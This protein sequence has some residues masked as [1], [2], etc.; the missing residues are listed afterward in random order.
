MTPL[1][2]W[3]RETA[4]LPELTESALR[5]YHLGKLRDIVGYAKAR[6]RYYRERFVEHGEIK[7]LAD[8]QALPFTDAAD[9]SRNPLDFLC[10]PPDD[11]SRIVTLRTSG[12]TGSGKRIFS[13][14]ED[15]E[16]T[17]EFFRY[18]M[19]TF[20]VRGD[21]ALLFMPGESPGGV[22]NLL[23]RGL[24][25]LG[26]A[27]R[28]YGPVSD[29]GGA[30]LALL[31]YGPDVAVGLPSQMLRLARETA[32]VFKLKSV[33]LASDYISPALE[34][35]IEAAWGC[36][37]FTHYGL[38]ESGLGGAVS[39]EAHDG[40]HM[41]DNDLYF[42][43]IDPASG[44]PLPDG[45]CGEIVF[46]TL[47]HAAMPLIRYRTGD[48]SRIIP[49]RCPC[50]SAVRRLGRIAGR[51][52]EPIR[53]RSGQSLSTTDLDDI[54]YKYP[55]IAAFAADLSSDGGTETLTITVKLAGASPSP[56]TIPE[57]DALPV[58]VAIKLGTPGFFTTG[59]LK[60]KITGVSS[61]V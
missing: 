57:L 5:G 10:V 52:A 29:Y 56:P 16:L 46:T 12:T 44:S 41:R 45:E 58:K 31:E 4:R 30:R 40:Y 60:R 2:K 21:R 15:Q 43:I 24:E 18:G 25:R 59:T 9:I 37:V 28:V 23:T 54:L 36:E 1:D 33:L 32:G 14:P 11:V 19:S 42:E 22:G 26:A 20:T 50:G 34:S 39:C 8:F 35:A 27:S 48:R 13:A 47:N 55:E 6:G 53:L 49:S 38:T 7:S 51:M 3:I 61:T 17:I